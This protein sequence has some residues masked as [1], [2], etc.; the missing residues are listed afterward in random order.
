MMNFFLLLL[1]LVF[2]LTVYNKLCPLARFCV[3]FTFEIDVKNSI[4]NCHI[5]WIITSCWGLQNVCCS[6]HFIESQQ[7]SNA[8]ILYTC[9]HLHVSKIVN[10]LEYHCLWLSLALQQTNKRN[11][12]VNFCSQCNMKHKCYLP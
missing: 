9:D 6:T 7:H 11:N 10:N 3:I 4:S 8:W 12:N 2:I 5:L 1:F